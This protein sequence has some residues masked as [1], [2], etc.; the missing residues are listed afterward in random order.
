M[1]FLKVS[2]RIV[3]TIL[4]K[5]LHQKKKK[6][7]THT[8]YG[9]RVL[10]W[11]QEWRPYHSRSLKELGLWSKAKEQK[12]R[13]KGNR[14]RGKEINTVRARHISIRNGLDDILPADR[15]KMLSSV[16]QE[17]SSS[18]VSTSISW[19]LFV[20]SYRKSSAIFFMTKTISKFFPSALV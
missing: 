17:V 20:H 9:D 19:S 1:H 15:I 3:Y 4:A 12:Q 14:D 16:I 13:L 6:T 5:H 7:W 2:P 10:R 8:T 11:S 18:L